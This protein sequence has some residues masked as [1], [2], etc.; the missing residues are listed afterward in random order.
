MNLLLGFLI[1][2]AVAGVAIAAML[3]VRR[4]APEGSFFSDG[5]RAVGRV[6]RARDGLLRPARVH[7]LP[8]LLQLRPV[9]RG[10]RGGGAPA[11]AAGRNRPVLPAR[12]RRGADGR[13]RLL[14]PVRRHR[15]VG[16]GWRR[17]PRDEVSLWAVAL[18]DTF[19]EYEPE[20]ASEQSAYDRWLDQTSYTRGGARR[21]HPRG[22]RHHP[23]PALGRALLHLRRHLRLHALLRRQRRAGEDAGP[24]DGLGRGSDHAMLL[25]L[26]S[27]T[28]RSTTVSAAFNPSPWSARSGTSTRRSRTSASSAPSLRRRGRRPLSAPPSARQRR[29]ELAA[30]PSRSCDGR[31]CLERLPGEPLERRAGDCLQPRERRTDRVD[32]RVRPRRCPDRN[33]RGD[34]HAVGERLVREETELADF[35]YARFRAEFEPAVTGV[36][37]HEAAPEPRTLR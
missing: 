29:L 17:A 2:A 15:G 37:R 19:H 16:C 20:S 12:P 23:E 4:R 34:V 36:G 14:R 9:A 7:H 1:V 24:P 18:F 25:L 11:R 28:A 3:L 13:A 8:R 10:S 33:R 6:R 22:C 32:A 26:G 5:D 27:S 30:A 31:D 21:S 35:Y